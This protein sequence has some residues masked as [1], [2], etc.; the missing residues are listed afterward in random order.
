[1]SPIV[2]LRVIFVITRIYRSS[3]F[4]WLSVNSWPIPVVASWVCGRLVVGSV[5]SNS[6]G[7]L[8]GCLL[9]VCVVLCQVDIPATGPSHVQRSLTECDVFE[10]DLETSKRRRLSTTRAIEP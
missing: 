7:D 4:L 1:M 2:H 3:G 10:C 5:G 8:K 6:A 9:C